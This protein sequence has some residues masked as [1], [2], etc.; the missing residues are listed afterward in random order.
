MDL[1]QEHHLFHHVEPDACITLE[2]RLVLP[3]VM[4]S[5]ITRYKT[6]VTARALVGGRLKLRRLRQKFPRIHRR[7]SDRS[8]QSRPATLRLSGCKTELVFVRL[9]WTLDLFAFGHAL[10]TLDRFRVIKPFHRFLAEAGGYG[11][12]SFTP[13]VEFRE[14]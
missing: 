9:C 14:G 12:C 13:G 11:G 10:R 6:Q 5:T 1:F 2:G 3:S 4:S 7:I 8:F